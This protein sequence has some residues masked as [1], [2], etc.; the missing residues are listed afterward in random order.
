[1]LT[2]TGE[3]QKHR[4]DYSH[5]PLSDVYKGKFINLL[6]TYLLRISSVSETLRLRHRLCL[7]EVYNLII[8][9]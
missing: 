8:A 4:G 3:N 6:D 9:V 7:Q 5:A 1:M 2:S